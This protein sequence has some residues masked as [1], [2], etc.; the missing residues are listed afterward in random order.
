MEKK[1]TKYWAI[2]SKLKMLDFKKAVRAKVE[3]LY[4]TLKKSYDFA[5]EIVGRRTK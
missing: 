1:E 3:K 2:L 4:E 5:V